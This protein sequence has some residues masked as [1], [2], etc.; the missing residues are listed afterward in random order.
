MKP[1]EPICPH[2]G[3]LMIKVSGGLTC[4]DGHT[5][6]LPVREFEDRSVLPTKHSHCERMVQVP[7]SYRSLAAIC[8]YHERYGLGGGASRR[9]GHGSST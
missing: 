3:K 7:L 6:I 8:D 5:R 4:I 2:C 1:I 9:S